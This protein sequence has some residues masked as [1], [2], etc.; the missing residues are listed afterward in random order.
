MLSNEALIKYIYCDMFNYGSIYTYVHHIPLSNLR[1]RRYVSVSAQPMPNTGLRGL[2]RGE[3]DA[4]EEIDLCDMAD[5]DVELVDDTMLIG[6][7]I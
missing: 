2:K 7:P 1:T 4:L 6:E 3:R 5:V